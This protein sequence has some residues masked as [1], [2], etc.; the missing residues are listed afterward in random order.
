[1][2]TFVFNCL[3]FLNSQSDLMLR[4]ALIA[5][6]RGVLKTLAEIRLDRGGKFNYLGRDFS[7]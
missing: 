4:G 2:G 7:L 1:M 3:F 6:S 5:Q